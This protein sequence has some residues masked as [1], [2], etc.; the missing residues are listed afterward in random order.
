MMTI[1][2]SLGD[3]LVA[4]LG[5]AEAHAVELVEQ[6]VRELEVGLVDLVDE[7]HDALVG[8]RTPAERA[9]A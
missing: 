8:A 7:Q 2:R 6:I 9:R 3:D 4:G 1:G 5:D